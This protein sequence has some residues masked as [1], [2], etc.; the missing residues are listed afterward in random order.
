MKKSIVCCILVVLILCSRFNNSY[1]QS[2]EKTTLLKDNFLNNNNGWQI[3]EN[4]TL[5][6]SISRNNYTINFTSFSPWFKKI[7]IPVDF[8]NAFKDDEVEVAFDLEMV[9]R[10]DA[11]QSGIGLTFDQINGNYNIVYIGE[12]NRGYI[13]SSIIPRRN[14]EFKTPIKDGKT[15]KFKRSNIYNIKI[16]KKLDNYKVLINGF[17]V[18]SFIHK[19]NIVLD[20]LYFTTGKYSISNLIVVKSTLV[21]ENLGEEKKFDPS[22][23]KMYVLLAGIKNYPS[24]DY[25][26]LNSPINDITAMRNF[27]NSSSG[28]LVPSENIIYL[29]EDKATRGNV[30]RN[31]RLMAQKATS[32]DVIIVY[33]T[34]HGGWGGYFGCYDNLL[35]YKELN[36]II[37]DS[38]ARNKLV[39]VDACFSGYIKNIVTPPGKDVLTPQDM[40]NMFRYSISMSAKNTSYL[41]S[42]SAD[43]ISYDGQPNSNSV[44][45][46]ALLQTI[47]DVTNKQNGQ[48]VTLSEVY[49]S[50]NKYF[51]TWNRNHSSDTHIETVNTTNGQSLISRQV[52]MHPQL[53]STNENNNLP[54]VIIHKN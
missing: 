41:L 10:N 36:Q 46:K 27:W 22:A 30:I 20:G 25:K 12:D 28:G 42:C 13:F 21:V 50:L 53:I 51:E 39:I 15:L 16:E 37:A 24:Q 44:F 6:A 54:I 49:Q 52:A 19:G 35:S 31:L 7:D 38:K 34:G 43:E 23:Y 5:S 3:I 9:D 33:L 32:N 45:T 2:F 26:P 17:L 8:K 14:G 18:L 29:P 11:N 47:N 1:S 4:E 48:I 40:Q